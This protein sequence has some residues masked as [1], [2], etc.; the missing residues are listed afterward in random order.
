MSRIKVG[1]RVNAKFGIGTVICIDKKIDLNFLVEHD[2]WNHGH[3]GNGYFYKN[4]A[5]DKK[6][7]KGIPFKNIDEINVALVSQFIEVVE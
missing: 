3:D 5:F 4:N 2:D 1:D 7:V 6:T